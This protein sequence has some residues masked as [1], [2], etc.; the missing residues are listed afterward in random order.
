[1]GKN[2]GALVIL[3]FWQGKFGECSIPI[4]LAGEK[5]WQTEGELSLV[6]SLK[7]LVFNDALTHD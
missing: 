3:K 4:L 6:Y 2:F 1:V 7:Q 5:F